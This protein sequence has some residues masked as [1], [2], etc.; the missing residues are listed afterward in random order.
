[1]ATARVP[2]ANTPEVALLNVINIDTTGQ[3][4]SP[5]I[6]I[7]DSDTIEFRNNA[8]FPVSI[9]FVC[10]NG[11]VFN[12]IA[13]IAP[14]T[15]TATQA[16]QKVQITTDYVITNLNTNFSQG[17]YSIEVGINTQTVPAP[18]LVPITGGNPPQGLS[19]VAVPQNGWIQ[20][21]LD[22]SYNVTWNPGTAFSG[23]ANPVSGSPVY[24]AQTGNQD[25]NYTLASTL[26]LHL[27]EAGTP[28]QDATY[29]NGVTPAAAGGGTVKIRS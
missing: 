20:F 15:T 26:P 10:A 6:I 3:S 27:A 9:Q 16:P 21:S 22:Q 11:P 28:G 29:D 8:P 23:P 25:V 1:M 13:R 17:P 7:G 5:G 18:L 2:I 14:N 19:T 24:H 4:Q 12:N